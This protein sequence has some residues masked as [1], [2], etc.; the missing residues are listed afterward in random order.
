MRIKELFAQDFID[1][2]FVPDSDE[3][4]TTAYTG[5]LLSDVLANAEAHS[6]LITIQAHVNTIAVACAALIPSVII[7]N[8][9][10]IDPAMIEAAKRESIALGSTKMSWFNFSCKIGSLLQK[11]IS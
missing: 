5:D 10:P 11:K 3:E 8:G 1:P 7:C 4:I 9:R 2:V 6:L